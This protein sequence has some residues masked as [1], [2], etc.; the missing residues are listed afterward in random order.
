MMN[1]ADWDQMMAAFRDV[2]E[3]LAKYRD[4]L[5]K[6]GFDRQETM[7]LVIQYQ[8]SMFSQKQ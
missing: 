3:T 8:I 7:R 5:L 2:A 1:T 4:E 6:Q